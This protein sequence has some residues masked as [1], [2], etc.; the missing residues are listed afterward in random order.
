M[1]VTVMVTWLAFWR[2]DL[3]LYLLAAPVT[4]MFGFAWYETYPADFGLV[5]A[6]VII[7]IGAYCAW[8]VLE[9][10]YDKLMR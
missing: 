5:G 6:V 2:R 9:N 4:V 10:L 3:F 1:V 7:A 8:K